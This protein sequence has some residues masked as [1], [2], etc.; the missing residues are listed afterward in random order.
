MI[1]RP[2]L[3][4]FL[5]GQRSMTPLA[6]TAIA[7]RARRLPPDNGAPGILSRPYAVIGA[8]ALAVGE[9][10]G[11]KLRSAPDR[12]VPAGLAARLVTGALAGAALAPRTQR[13]EAAFMGAAGAVLGGYLGLA[14]RKRAIRRFGQTKSGLV[15]DALT[16]AATALILRAPVA[17]GPG[18]QRQR[19]GPG[20]RGRAAFASPRRR[21]PP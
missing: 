14:V 5:A 13:R 15:E 6:A 9:L 8:G 12:T 2:F 3:I 4:G 17:V 21:E 19:A 7:A 11:D 16:V 20:V 18:R 1:P 10:L